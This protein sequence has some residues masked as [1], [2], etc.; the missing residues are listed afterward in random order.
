[1]RQ[2]YSVKVLEQAPEIGEIGA[3]IQPGPNAF[4]AL[5]ALGVGEA[6]RNR[7]VDTDEMVMHD[8]LDETRVGRIPTGETFR[9]RFGN[10]SAVSHRADLHRL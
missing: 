1:V 7:A 5:D 8:A 2:G 3:G 10:P 6:A 4:H 9:Q